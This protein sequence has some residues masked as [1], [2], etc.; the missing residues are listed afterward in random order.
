L[1]ESTAL[2]WQEEVSVAASIS[3][4]DLMDSRGGSDRFQLVD[5]RSPSEY[6]TGHI[7][8]AVNIPMEQIESR[9]RDLDR[10]D[11]IVLICQSGKRA[12]MVAGLLEPCGK[13]LRVLEGGTSAWVKAGL[14]TVASLR[15]RWSLER[16]VRL[17]AGLL[18]LIAVALALTVSFYWI[19]LA[20][21]VG[22]GL[23]F[24]GLTDVCPMAILLSLLP[25][26]RSGHCALGGQSQPSGKPVF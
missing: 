1:Q 6:A 22:L 24:A 12:R 23:T 15:T 13:D 3:V 9:M 17:G 19:Y 2:L 26:N 20:G 25:W 11:P 14:S 4:R 8:G 5:V 7:P 10:D 18:V 21:F 16:Q